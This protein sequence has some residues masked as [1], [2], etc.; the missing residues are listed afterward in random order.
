MK[1]RN[2][3]Y[4][5]ILIGIIS[6]NESK[7]KAEN[8]DFIPVKLID[9]KKSNSSPLIVA[10]GLV[11]TEN[12]SRLAFK[13]GGVIDR[14]FVR[15]GQSF[16]KGDLL[17]TLKLTEIEAQVLQ[18]KL[19]FEKSKRDYNRV[20]NLYRDSV[21]TLEQLQNTKTLLEISEKSLEQASFNKKYAF[22]YANSSGFVTKKIGNEGEIIQGGFP[23]LAINEINNQKEWIVRIGVSES[24]WIKTKES[25]NCSIQINDK[26]FLGKISQKSKAIDGSSGTFQIDVKILNPN[27]DFAIGMFAKV[28]IN[29]SNSTNIITIPYDAVVEANGK[30]AYVFIPNSN[31]SVIKVPIVIESFNENEVEVSK[32]LENYNQV[33]VGNSPFLNE[34]SKIKIIR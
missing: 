24:D 11:Y 33:I 4:V 5:I 6:C 21:A 23:V 10:T 32:G 8:T 30:N 25:D 15:E 19:G 9:L 34:K 2:L 1:S 28:I 22:I 14:I 12:E 20:L 26:N 17:A 31:S 16:E 7:P 27:Q 13:V 18:A 3:L 29:V